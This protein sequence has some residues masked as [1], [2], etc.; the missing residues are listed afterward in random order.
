MP[1]PFYNVLYK[2]KEMAFME[3]IRDFKHFI[4]KNKDKLYA[5]AEDANNITIEDEW[6]QDDQ[7]DEVYIQEEKVEKI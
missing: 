6:M 2:M 7:W 1:Y 5:I 3:G 4:E